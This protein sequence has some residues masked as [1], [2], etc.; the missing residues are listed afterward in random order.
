MNSVK[1]IQYNNDN[2]DADTVLDT[3]SDNETIPEEYI[4]EQ[5]QP[6]PI[7]V[8]PKL[9][10]VPPPLK[11][12]AFVLDQYDEDNEERIYI[13][14]AIPVIPIIKIKKPKINV[15]NQTNSQKLIKKK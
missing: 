12:N 2:N 11:R 7:F 5:E 10:I 13:S 4:K 3:G 15:S 14:Q 6:K 9:I 8:A 1:D